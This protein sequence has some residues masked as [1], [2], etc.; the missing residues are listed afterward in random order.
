MKWAT[1]AGFT[2]SAR[3]ALPDATQEGR[4]GLPVHGDRGRLMI[5]WRCDFRDILVQRAERELHPPHRSGIISA[6]RSSSSRSCRSARLA[7]R[8]C[9]RF[10]AVGQ[11]V[12]QLHAHHVR[13]GCAFLCPPE[14]RSTIPK[15]W[16]TA[17]SGSGPA[18]STTAEKQALLAFDSAGCSNP[19]SGTS[20][21]R[22][23][24]GCAPFVGDRELS[25]RASR[26][27]LA[28]AGRALRSAS[29][30][31]RYRPAL[32]R[33]GRIAAQSPP[34]TCAAPRRFGAGRV[35]LS[36]HDPQD[37]QQSWESL[38]SSPAVPTRPGEDSRCRT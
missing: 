1:S 28:I 12:G 22:A 19:S 6:R 27:I 16:R 7:R 10:G 3:A 31:L 17:L 15:S 23:Y 4:S 5:G 25:R 9:R 11:P 20:P 8:R 2:G 24:R 38:E 13:P 26:A 33:P 29:V 35:A 34:G 14:R 32:G 21:D 30:P 18:P 37:L 36:N